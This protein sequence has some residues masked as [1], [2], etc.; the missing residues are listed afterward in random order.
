M[1]VLLSSNGHMVILTPGYIS[2]RLMQIQVSP[3]P[4]FPPFKKDYDILLQPLF[5]EYFNLPSSVVSRVHPL[6]ADTT[7]TPFSTSVDQ[8]VPYA[9]TSSTTQ[10]SQ[11][12]VPHQGVEEQIQG[13]QNAQ[14]DN[15]PLLHNI[16]MDLSSVE[17]TS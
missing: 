14:V 17:S 8:D 10:E 12:P 2:S 5:D 11:A 16:S 13:N 9:S 7:D 3:T 1:S 15:A 6:P 4:Y